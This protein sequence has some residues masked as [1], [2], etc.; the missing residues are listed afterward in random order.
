MP[1]AKNRVAKGSILLRRRSTLP[2]CV[3]YLSMLC[4]H[5][6]TSTSFGRIL[7]LF[8][9]EF[10]KK[11]LFRCSAQSRHICFAPF[12]KSLPLLVQVLWILGTV[13]L[14]CGHTALVK[15]YKDVIVRIRT[16][17]VACAFC[18][19]FFEGKCQNRGCNFNSFHYKDGYK[20]R[21]PPL[22]AQVLSSCAACNCLPFVTAVHL[23]NILAA[24]TTKLDGKAF[25]NVNYLKYNL[26]K[27]S[28][29]SF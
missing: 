3:C 10:R 21:H 14:R 2:I 23:L 1:R 4:S 11:I 27:T 16:R 24:G 13:A 18:W 29:H 17:D 5:Q 19:A 25:Y 22:V 20:C 7:S 6:S 8:D 9:G 26:L 12:A 15:H 28:Y